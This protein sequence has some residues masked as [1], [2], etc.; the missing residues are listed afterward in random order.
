MKLHIQYLTNATGAS[1]VVRAIAN[2]RNTAET[3]DT[4]LHE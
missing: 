4:Y 3:I 1:L 2:G